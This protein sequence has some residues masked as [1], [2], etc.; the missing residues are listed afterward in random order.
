MS[1]LSSTPELSL[2]HLAQAP[3]VRGEGKPPLLIQL[4][5]IGSNEHDL[6]SFAPLLDPRFLVISARAPHRVGPDNFAWF[7]VEF[8]PQGYNVNA[9]Q[10]QSS[11]EELTRF[12]GAATTAYDADPQ[13][14]YLIGFSQGASMS[15]ALALSHPELV[16][17][18]CIMSGRLLPEVESW[19]APKEQVQGLPLLVTH[20]TEDGVIPIR[21]ARQTR[22]A[23][24][25]LPVSLTYQEYRMAHEV[26][27][28][29]LE[30]VKG[31]LTAR[32]DG[33]RRVE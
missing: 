5:G 25:D 3:G 4:H 8:L 17:G 19:F 32:L 11:F 16:A 1:Q 9:E 20:G 13:R 7:E 22:Q 30:L 14:I 33:P 29:N 31:W 23:L 21:Y 26:S 15:L 6:F 2:K 24:A 12:I 10:L 18:A 27:P 28:A